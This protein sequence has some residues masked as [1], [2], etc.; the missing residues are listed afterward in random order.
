MS[1]FLH[2]YVTRLPTRPSFLYMITSQGCW[3]V[4]KLTC[5]VFS[6]GTILSSIPKATQRSCQPTDLLIPR[7]A[8]PILVQCVLASW[9][10]ESHCWCTFSQPLQCEL[11]WRNWT[12]VVPMHNCVIGIK[13][14]LL[15]GTVTNCIQSVVAS[16]TEY[17][18]INQA[19]DSGIAPSELLDKHP[20]WQPF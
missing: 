15:P 14:I 19:F 5:V 3:R 6:T 10:E 18:A 9:Q 13:E 17:Q 1:L 16:C 2:H 8:S 7:K 20:A 4:P 11:W 12:I